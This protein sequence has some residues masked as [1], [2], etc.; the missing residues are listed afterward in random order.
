MELDRRTALVWMG[1]VAAAIGGAEYFGLGDAPKAITGPGY[2]RDPNL[3][4]PVQ[5]WSRTMT[6]EQLAS[7][8]RLCDFILPAEGPA[9]SATALKVHEFI[10]EW[11]SAPYPDQAADWLLILAGLDWMKGDAR[12]R[13][14]ATS[15]TAASADVRHALLTDL[16]NGA[17]SGKMAP[18]GFY[19]RVRK[20]V[21]G[22][23]YTT[24]AGFK[25]IGYIG[26]VA[27]SSYPGPSPEVLAA[28]EQAYVRLGLTGKPATG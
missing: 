9:P 8:A 17:S 12:R 14:N 27:L 5:Y 23:Y 28:L 24:E 15:F 19:A 16:A 18:A 20:L 22:A 1:I 10:D 4:D 25:D 21:I 11:I 26:N 13:A 6:G 2:G 7:I 3:V